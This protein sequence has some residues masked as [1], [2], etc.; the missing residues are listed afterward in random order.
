ML[1]FCYVKMKT[2]VD[3]L[4][5]ISMAVFLLYKI[6]I[7]FYVQ[8]YQGKFVHYGHVNDIDNMV[9]YK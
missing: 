2:A 9:N 8:K 3:K 6:L 5:S 4:K 7:V 1:K